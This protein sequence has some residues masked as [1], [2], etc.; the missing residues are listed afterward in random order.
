MPA[1]AKL[2][3]TIHTLNSIPGYSETL[4]TREKIDIVSE[5][6]EREIN[7]FIKAHPEYQAS[8]FNLGLIKAW[9]SLYD[10]IYS[11]W[12]LEICLEDLRKDGLLEAAP[13]TAPVEVDKSRGVVEVR[14]DALMEYQVPPGEAAALA[15]LA[16]DPNL[17]DHARKARDHRL[18]LLAG[19]QRRQ[20]ST[21]PRNYGQRVVI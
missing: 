7:E 11:K 14:S 13:P 3:P 16:D 15:K 18:A 10:G 9:L 4:T 20:G 21:L 12:N 8:E 1:T 17:S 19:Q 2:F 5:F 6:E